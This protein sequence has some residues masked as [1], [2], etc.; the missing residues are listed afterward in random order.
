MGWAGLL[1]SCGS[2]TALGEEGDR[3]TSMKVNTSNDVRLCHE[4]LRAGAGMAPNRLSEPSSNRMTRGA[5]LR[6]CDLKCK[7]AAV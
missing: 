3:V 6:N 4:V 1:L 7:N 2:Q 5:S